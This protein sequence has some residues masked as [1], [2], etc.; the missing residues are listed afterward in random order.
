MLIN[1]NKNVSNYNTERWKSSAGWW[2]KIAHWIWGHK[3]QWKWMKPVMICFRVLNRFCVPLLVGANVFVFI[4]IFK[5]LYIRFKNNMVIQNAY[6]RIIFNRNIHTISNLIRVFNYEAY[7]IRMLFLKFQSWCRC[8]WWLFLSPCV[9]VPSQISNN[10]KTST[11]WYYAWSLD[12][13]IDIALYRKVC[14]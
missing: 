8:S 6:N 13:K 9:L 7:Y 14:E 2:S 11:K 12:K 1:K 5:Y 4:F 10:L 3:A